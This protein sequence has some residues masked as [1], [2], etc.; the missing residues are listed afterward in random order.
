MT[1]T[2][3]WLLVAAGFVLAFLIGFGWQFARADAFQAQLDQTRRE[4]TFQRLESTLAAATIAAQSGSYEPARQL[5]S[6][7]FTRL[8][9][10]MQQA[11]PAGRAQLQQILSQRDQVITDLSRADPQS[12]AVLVALFSR[13]RVAMGEAPVERAPAKSTTSA[14]SSP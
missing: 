5:A 3:Q 11:P 14:A 13:Y 9:G 2:T 8:Q 1:K 12:A 10:S 4:L 6:D 7:F